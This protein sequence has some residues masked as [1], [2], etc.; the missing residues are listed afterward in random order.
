MYVIPGGQPCSN[1]SELL[2]S[3]EMR[4]VLAEVR[5]SV[6]YVILDTA[7]VGM[8]TDT[9]VLAK[10]ADAAVFTVKQDYVSCSGILEGIAELAQSRI[11]ITGC[12][13]NGAKAGIG[14]YGYRNYHYYGRYGYYGSGSNRDTE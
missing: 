7:P 12:V 6:D 8:L 13:L 9:A 3:R 2:N 1:A 10:E 14:G 11:H 5:E 4:H